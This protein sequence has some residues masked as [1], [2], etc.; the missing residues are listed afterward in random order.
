[1]KLA[2]NSQMGHVFHYL[3]T[4]IS[5]LSWLNFSLSSDIL[6]ARNSCLFEKANFGCCVH[7]RVFSRVLGSRTFKIVKSISSRIITCS[8]K[9]SQFRP[10]AVMSFIIHRDR[11]RTRNR[12]RNR[13]ISTAIANFQCNQVIYEEEVNFYSHLKNQYFTR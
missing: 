3:I 9:F 11:K 12:L 5:L 4:Y 6:F 13:K 1:M 7:V 8:E 10:L 2:K